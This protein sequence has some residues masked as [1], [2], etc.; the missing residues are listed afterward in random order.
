MKRK[1]MMTMFSVV[2]VL[3][4]MMFV[5]V[6]AY[7]VNVNVSTTEEFI[8]AWNGADQSGFNLSTPPSIITLTQD[9]I[10]PTDWPYRTSGRGRPLTRILTIQGNHTLHGALPAIGHYSRHGQQGH[11]ILN[12]PT[13]QV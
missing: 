2:I 3:S 10:L 11:L 12:G 6:T 8:E 1:I 4:S 7:A 5:P 13:I 9:I